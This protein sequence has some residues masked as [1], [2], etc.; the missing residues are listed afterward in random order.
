MYSVKVV[1][2]SKELTA[3]ER[4][5]LKDTSN[6]IKLDKA[7][8]GEEKVVIS[9]SGYAILSVHND[10]ADPTDYE[11]YVIFDEVG[12]KFV[13]GSKSFWNSF[14]DIFMEMSGEEEEYEIE[15]YKLPSKNYNGKFLTC[16]IV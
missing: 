9:P 6:A 1:E 3:K 2:C 8:N 16:S 11:Q 7:C 5:R 14:S 13:T 10:K 15:C 4:I 12:N